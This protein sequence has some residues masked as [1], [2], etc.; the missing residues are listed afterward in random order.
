MTMTTTMKNELKRMAGHYAPVALGVVSGA[1][2]AL[3][4]YV[5]AALLRIDGAGLLAFCV[6][7]GAVLWASGV[8]LAVMLWVDRRE[9]EDFAARRAA[10]RAQLKGAGRTTA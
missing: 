2:S 4:L 10:L 3:H 1:T 6:V 5:A 9:R 8:F 7:S